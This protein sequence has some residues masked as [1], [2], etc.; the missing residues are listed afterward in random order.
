MDFALP[1]NKENEV[2]NF[3]GKK[4]KNH[5]DLIKSTHYVHHSQKIGTNQKFRKQEP[6][7][8]SMGCEESAGLSFMVI[9][10]LFTH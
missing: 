8:D 1:F 3:P 2:L 9:P 4:T 5:Q 7:D 10:F 6:S